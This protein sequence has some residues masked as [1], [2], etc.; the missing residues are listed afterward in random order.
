MVAMLI[1]SDFQVG[2]GREVVTCPR[3]HCV[4]TNKLHSDDWC[5]QSVYPIHK[6]RHDC[7]VCY[8]ILKTCP[9]SHAMLAKKID[10]KHE[11]YSDDFAKNNTKV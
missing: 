9:Y 7:F 11:I 10:R 4:H 2:I 3:A 8:P 1:Y 6:A 5:E